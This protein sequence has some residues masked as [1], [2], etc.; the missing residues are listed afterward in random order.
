MYD[1][2]SPVVLYGVLAP[3]VPYGADA[4]SPDISTSAQEGKKICARFIY[5][6]NY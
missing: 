6:F 2:V 3:A 4:P 5:F 1:G